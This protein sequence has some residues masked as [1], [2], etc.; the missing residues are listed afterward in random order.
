MCVER[1]F[2]VPSSVTMTLHEAIARVLSEVVPR[3]LRV[4]EIRRL[5]NERRLYR[6]RDG[7]LPSIQ[8]FHARIRNYPQLFRLDGSLSPAVVHLRSTDSSRQPDPGER[9]PRRRRIMRLP[10]TDA[11]TEATPAPRHSSREWYWEGNVQARIRDHLEGQGWEIRRAADTEGR[12]RG[13]DLLA[14]Q[15]K[16]MRVVE[17]KG[18]PSRVY[19]RGPWQGQ[20]KRTQ[21]STQAGHWYAGAVLSAM[22]REARMP[23][24]EVYL[25]FPDVRR[26]RN[27]LARTK[28]GL[29][30][31]G[32]GVYLVDL[33]G[34][35]HEHLS[36]LRRRSQLERR[37]PSVERQVGR[38]ASPRGLIGLSTRLSSV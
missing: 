38:P 19:E 16:R 20:P 13:V 11:S 12:R 15:G 23:Q 35:V 37:R 6:M 5:V 31:L 29:E 32:F 4:A 30:R 18:Y 3:G 33:E 10:A 22:L 14:V 9:L 8:Q 2:T 24:A 7:G 34:R 26:Y 17:V 1:G 28:G 36:T 27:L 21:P 25:G